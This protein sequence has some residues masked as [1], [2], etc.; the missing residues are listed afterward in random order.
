MSLLS[1]LKKRSVRRS[2]MVADRWRAH[3][4]EA[5]HTQL[6]L[7]WQVSLMFSVQAHSEKAACVLRPI[8]HNV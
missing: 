3:L 8:V 6:A 7:C 2:S 5:M 4:V 1:L